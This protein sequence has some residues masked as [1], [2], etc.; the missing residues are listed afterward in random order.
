MQLNN[1][2]K[3]PSHP[4]KTAI[5]KSGFQEGLNDLVEY[6]SVSTSKS[7]GTPDDLEGSR[8]RMLDVL[9]DL[10]YAEKHLPDHF[11]RSN[12]I[13][14]LAAKNRT[15]IPNL[16]I[17]GAKG[18]G[19]TFLFRQLLRSENWRSFLSQSLPTTEEVHYQEGEIIAV[20]YPEQV[21]EKPAT[22]VK[23]V[24]P[25][26][27]RM[28]SKDLNIDEWRAVW[29]DVIAWSCNFEIDKEGAGI[30]FLNEQTNTSASY[31]LIFDGLE[32]LF[33]NYFENEQ[34]QIALKSLLQDVPSYISVIPNSKVGVMPFIRRDILEHVIKQNLGQFLD[35]YKD[36]ELKW[37]RT[38]ALRLVAWIMNHYEIYLLLGINDQDI[39]KSS[40][41]QLTDALN[42]LWGRKL[43]S[44]QSREARSAK[45]ILNILS[46]FNDEVQSRDLVR[47][48]AEA[49]KKEMES[50]THPDDRIL[51]PRAIRDAF[52]DVGK[53]KLDEVK[54]ENRGNRYERVL[55]KL[56]DSSSSIK[57]PTEQI[58]FL[59]NEEVSLLVDQGV[60]KK[61]NSRYYIAELFRLGM[62]IDRG[63]GKVKTDF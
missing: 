22:W 14:S 4:L 57:F 23:Q 36:Y 25:Y 43:G 37:D 15:R 33:P 20:T 60:L 55:K 41:E 6:F 63:K 12:A 35:R 52:L 17:I 19:K 40:E 58:D 2:I 61:F 7:I 34:Q 50:S 8:K 56:E 54:Q 49:I 16:V 3:N 30:K 53:E 38:E 10:I 27:I 9:P 21:E 51:S 24:K 18:S 59:T 26:L 13:R 46:N 62:G 31:L 1:Y 5:E 44:D 42:Q 39:L 48:L 29:L 47:F 45:K 32:D 11:Y 28:L